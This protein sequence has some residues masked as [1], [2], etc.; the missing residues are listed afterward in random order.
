MTF[1]FKN[2]DLGKAFFSDPRVH[3]PWFLL[4][5]LLLSY[6]QLPLG[7]KICVGG[8]GI[9]CPLFTA[10]AGEMA[11]KGRLNSVLSG[12]EKFK[13]EPWLWGLLA[14]L[15][16]GT[17]LYRLMSLSLWPTRD[18]GNYSFAAMELN[19]NSIMP[20]FYGIGEQAPVF[21]YLQA[22]FVKFVEPSLFSIWLFPALI[23]LFIVPAGYWAA[24]GFASKK[25]SLVFA[26]LAAGSFWP[27]LLGRF[28]LSWGLFCSWQLIVFGMT[29]RLLKV[30]KGVQKRFDA[31]LL[32]LMVGAGFYIAPVLW[33]FMA[34][35]LTAGI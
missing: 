5:S 20:F 13:I 3:F 33:L 31:S 18:D 4:S 23:S 7:W 1:R 16:F 2:L 6:G 26:F 35:A 24:R 15:A 14:A 29:A 11:G 30:D 27:V 32:G 8:F 21:R 22:G 19:R 28:C 10:M 12:S 17:R 34:S 25:F 9:L